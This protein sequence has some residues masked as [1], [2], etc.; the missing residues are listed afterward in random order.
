M[1]T[2]NRCGERLEWSREYL[3]V[4]IYKV[5][6]FFFWKFERSFDESKV[7]Q[8]QDFNNPS[9]VD[10]SMMMH[11]I[12]HVTNLIYILDEFLLRNLKDH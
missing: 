11:A 8:L 4:Y 10:L 1:I 3:K 5:D 7:L 2:F 12:M 9:S 6:D